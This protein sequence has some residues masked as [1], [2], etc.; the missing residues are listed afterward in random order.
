MNFTK[1]LGKTKGYRLQ[2]NEYK[3]QYMANAR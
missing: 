3:Q 1:T 2:V